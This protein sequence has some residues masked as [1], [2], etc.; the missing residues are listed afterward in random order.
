MILIDWLELLIA[1]A[2][3]LHVPKAFT[4][5]Y[6]FVACVVWRS[7][8][9]S[10]SRGLSW[11]T[12]SLKW[13]PSLVS[14]FLF[15]VAY[16][17]GMLAWGLWSWQSDRPDLVN[18]LVLP[19]LFLWSGLQSARLGRSWLIRILLSYSLGSLIYVLIAL[20]VSRSHWWNVGQLFHSSVD[21]PWG[22]PRVINVRS[23]EQNAM[24]ALSL[25]PAS[26][27]GLMGAKAGRRQWMAGS[28]LVVAALGGYALWSLQGRLGWLVLAVASVPCLA[29][30]SQLR[31]AWTANGKKLLVASMAALSIFLL[32]LRPWR[33]RLGSAGWSQGLCDERL[34]LH[35]S[36]LRHGWG[37]PWGGRLLAAPY[38]LCNGVPALLAPNGGNVTMAHNVFLDIFLDAGF[39]PAALLVF[40]ILPLV[41]ML[42]KN[43]LRV[44]AR[45]AWDVGML[46]CWSWLVLIFAEWSF[47][48]LLYS[49][50][51]LYYF[52]FFALAGMAAMPLRSVRNPAS[53]HL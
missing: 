4:L 9:D 32:V 39:V 1:F 31:A 53:V 46:V 18:A 49:D 47:Q 3:G 11:S 29:E 22:Y 17:C 12:P 27:H 33:I 5:V 42:V 38:E 23:I 28:A 13:W 2:V 26:L 40:A 36:I 20:G 14:V 35:A 15:S 6:G 25:L 24:P 19:V 30:V 44:W 8:G 51:L 10:V 52:S 37:S 50:G 34:S 7:L 21:V 16:V 43:L 48:P 45:G 41:A